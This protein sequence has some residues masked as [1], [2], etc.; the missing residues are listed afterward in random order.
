M[1]FH[2]S[3]H[4]SC[5]VVPESFRWLVSHF[6]T[7]DAEIVIERI[8]Y[9][10]GRQK[11]DVTKLIEIIQKEAEVESDKKYSILDIFRNATLAKHSFFLWF[12]W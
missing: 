12:I 3:I 11:P 4:A 9:I 10:N 2:F 6:K 7:K 8:A 5:S 1:C